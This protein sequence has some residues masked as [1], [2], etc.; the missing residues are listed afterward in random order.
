MTKEK[1]GGNICKLSARA[2]GKEANEKKFE[3]DR[4]KFLT[5]ERRCAKIPESPRGD[6]NNRIE[7]AQRNLKKLEKSS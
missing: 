2:A 6:S 1:G 5:N 3:K 7:T 4:K